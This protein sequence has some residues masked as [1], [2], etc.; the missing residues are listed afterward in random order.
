MSELRQDPV[1]GEWVIVAPE[2]GKR[3]E[4]MKPVKSERRPTPREDCP[5]CDLEHTGNWPPIFSFPEDATNGNWKEVVL[6][7]KYPALVHNQPGC[8]PIVAEGPYKHMQGLGYHDL[9]ITRDHVTPFADLPHTDAMRVMF[10]LQKRFKQLHL[11]K[12]IHYTSAFQNW[13]A[14]VGASQYHPHYQILSL[15]VIPPAV[16]ESFEACRKHMAKTGKCLHCSLMK[17]ELKKRKT[18]IDKNDGAVVFAPYASWRPFQMRVMPR[19]HFAFFEETPEKDVAA[20]VSMLQSAL[21]RLRK[22]VGDPDFNFYLHTGPMTNA[23]SRY[24]SYHWH[25]DIIPNASA[26]IGGFELGTGIKIITVMPELTAQVM[27][28]KVRLGTEKTK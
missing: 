5:F 24:A 25:F 8:S 3:P 10:A 11:D 18:I 2:R 19:R 21:K 7:N 17:Y 1:S 15:P 16:K 20:V 14:S 12:C 6:P 28:G 4:T 13:G 26:P 27:T 9:V 22:Y 23:R